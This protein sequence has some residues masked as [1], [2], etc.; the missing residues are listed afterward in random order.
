MHL[1]LPWQ[2]PKYSENP[3]VII[4]RL[5]AEDRPSTSLM[6]TT[7]VTVTKYVKYRRK[8]TFVFHKMRG[9]YLL[10]KKRFAS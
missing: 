5:A 6:Q 8:R 2:K 1:D 4:D 9:N 7:G 3:C 10:A